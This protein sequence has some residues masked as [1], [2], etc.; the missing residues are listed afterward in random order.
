MYR[1]PSIYYMLQLLSLSSDQADNQ[2]N[3]INLFKNLFY[4]HGMLVTKVYT[5][6]AIDNLSAACTFFLH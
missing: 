4:L 2:T 1:V 5:D 6:L 3:V